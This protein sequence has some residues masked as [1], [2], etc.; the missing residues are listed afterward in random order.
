MSGR[1]RTRT[2]SELDKFYWAPKNDHQR[3]ARTGILE[4]EVS[5]LVGPP[6]VGKTHTAL[7]TAFE[8]LDNKK[9]K[10]HKVILS[11]PIIGAGEDLG[12]LPGFAEE[13]L[14]PYLIS[15]YDLIEKSGHPR[16]QEW[17]EPD[18]GVVEILPTSLMLGITVENTVLILDDS[19][20]LT[21]LQYQLILTRLGETGKI[22][23]CGDEKQLYIKKGN[24][25]L[26]DAV[27]K[28][29]HSKYVNVVRFDV[30]D[31]C[32]SGFVREVIEAYLTS[33]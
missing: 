12:Y 3:Q 29:Q 23:F 30:E 21:P 26:E 9:S 33:N 13:K 22:I 27:S 16:S 28:F 18:N 32:R 4:K 24:S 10:I 5:F 1:R 14:S 25:G 17:L 15:F 8:L 6:G 2:H 7:Y 31:I 11:K 20:N 19:Q